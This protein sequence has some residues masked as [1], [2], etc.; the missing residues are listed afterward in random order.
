MLT[1]FRLTIEE[2]W[3]S[4]KPVIIGSVSSRTPDTHV[5]V[6]NEEKPIIRVD[7]YGKSD[8]AFCFSES[9]IWRDWVIIGFP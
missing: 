9:V 8:E 5:T 7:V 6:M 3:I 2:P 4:M 1:Q